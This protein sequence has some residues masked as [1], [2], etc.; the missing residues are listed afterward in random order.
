VT[1]CTSEIMTEFIFDTKAQMFPLRDFIVQTNLHFVI[2]LKEASTILNLVPETQKG[3]L[4][5]V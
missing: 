5:M 1:L 4:R 3:Q 2:L